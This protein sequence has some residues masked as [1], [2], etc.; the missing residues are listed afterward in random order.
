MDRLGAAKLG[1]A[2][3]YCNLFVFPKKG[4]MPL[5]GFVGKEKQKVLKREVNRLRT[6]KSVI[7]LIFFAF[8]RRI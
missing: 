8:C 3:A 1:D 2:S 5:L 6:Q 7:R 4:L